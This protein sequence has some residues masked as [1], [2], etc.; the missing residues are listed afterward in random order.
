MV[1]LTGHSD[2]LSG[3]LFLILRGRISLT[4]VSTYTPESIACPFTLYFSLR[5]ISQ[6]FK[7]P[8]GKSQVFDLFISST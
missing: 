4:Y 5:F 1:A 2:L 7:L 3:F 8:K 6:E